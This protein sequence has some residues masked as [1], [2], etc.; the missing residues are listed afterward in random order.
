MRKKGLEFLDMVDL[1]RV[2]GFQQLRVFGCMKDLEVLYMMD[3]IDA[4]PVGRRLNRTPSS[5]SCPWVATRSPMRVP[6]RALEWPK[7]VWEVCC[8]TLLEIS[9]L[10]IFTIPNET[11]LVNDGARHRMY[12]ERTYTIQRYE[13]DHFMVR[14]LDFVALFLKVFLLGSSEG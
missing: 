12:V 13:V 6:R 11:G 10:G 8:Q 2:I 4:K 3:P 9:D 7:L 14:H 1:I 5:R